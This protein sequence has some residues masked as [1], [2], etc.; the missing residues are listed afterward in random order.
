MNWWTVLGSAVSALVGAIGGGLLVHWL[1]LR[2][3]VVAARRT[4]RVAFLLDAYRKLIDA[5]ERE[6]LGPERR[7]NLE[8]ALADIVLLGGKREIDEA[9]KFMQA[10]ARDGGASMTPVIDALRDSLR[11][12]LALQSVAMPKLFNLRLYLDS[13][14]RPDTR[15]IS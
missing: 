8:S 13:D 4:Q 1:T 15:Q 12:E 3:E 11:T 2:R 14:D 7:D 9:S 10:F 5:S 6:T